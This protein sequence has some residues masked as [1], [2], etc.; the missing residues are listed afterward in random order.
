MNFENRLAERP[1]INDIPT[2]KQRRRSVHGIKYTSKIDLTEFVPFREPENTV[3]R[4]FRTGTNGDVFFDELHCHF[5]GQSMAS[6]EK[7]QLPPTG[8]VLKKLSRE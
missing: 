2:I 8:G 4:L 1:G 3:R 6:H 7:R 5:S